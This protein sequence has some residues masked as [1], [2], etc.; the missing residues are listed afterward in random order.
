MTDYGF[1]SQN[2]YW[3]SQYSGMT[4]IFRLPW[5]SAFCCLLGHFTGSLPIELSGYVSYFAWCCNALSYNL[6]GPTPISRPT[7]TFSYS[8]DH[9]FCHT[10]VH[11]SIDVCGCGWKYTEK[12][13]RGHD[14]VCK[15]GTFSACSIKLYLIFLPVR[16]LDGERYEH[17]GKVLH[18]CHRFETRKA[19]GWRECTSMAEQKHVDILY[20]IGH[21]YAISTS[22]PNLCK[23]L[24]QIF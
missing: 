24:F 7:Y 20:R 8:N 10:L 3:R 12:R 15:R 9:S 11:R 5:C 2:L 6:D 17:Y 16:H 22:I 13:Y 18:L 21:R 4:L 23:L 1:S 19:K 14:D